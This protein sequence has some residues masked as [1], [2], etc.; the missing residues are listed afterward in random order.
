MVMRLELTTGIR[1]GLELETIIYSVIN[2]LY[3]REN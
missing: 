1:S 2:L 3:I